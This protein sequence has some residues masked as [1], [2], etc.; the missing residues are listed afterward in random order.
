MRFITKI[1]TAL[2]LFLALAQVKAIGPF[3]VEDIQVEGLQRVEL[4]TFFTALPIR[5]GETI[6]DARVPNIIRSLYKTGNFDFVKLERVDATLKVLVVERPVISSIVLSGNK[7]LKSEQLL[8]NM[9]SSGIEKGEVLNSFILDK[10]EQAITNEYFNN[11]HYHLGIKKQIIDLSRNRVQLKIDIKEGKSARIKGLNII[12]NKLFSDEELLNNMESATGGLFSFLMDDN[13]YS[14]SGLEKDIEAVT[15]FYK[16]RGYLK[17]NVD[18]T[19]VS[20]SDNREEVYISLN[21]TEGNVFNIKNVNL[22]GE[23]VY[24]DDFLK[25]II[26]YNEGDN[27]SQAINTFIEEQIKSLLGLKGFAFAEVRVIPEIIADT[28]E[29]DL[30]VI[31]DPGERYYANDISFV[32]NYIT[33]D[34]VFRREAR[35][36][37]GEPL[38]SSLVERS[39]QRI[40]RL[41][42]AE[43]VNVD[44]RKSEELGEADI[45]YTVKER[46]SSEATFSLGYN[47][48][49]GFQI[50]GGVTNR[51]F[52]GE[53]KTI[54]VN[55]SSNKAV[56]SLNLNYSDPYFFD[57]IIGLSSSLSYKETDFSEFNTVGRSLD[58]LALGAG[59][60]YPI[61]ETSNISFGFNFQD[62]TLN[63]P[64]LNNQQDQRVLDFFELLGANGR[65]DNS[66]DFNVFSLN[67]GY[68]KNTLNRFIFPTSG[69]SHNVGLE[70]ATPVG[71]IEYYK[72][73]YDYKHYFPISN[74]GWIFSI[75]A[76]LGFGDG[77]GDTDRLP[78]F[79]NY[80]AGGSNSLR[81]FEGNTIG[82]KSILR[83]LQTLTVSNPIPGSSSTS[84]VLPPENDLLFINNRFSVG[85]NAKAVASFEL[86]FPTPFVENKNNVR[87]S[88][89]VD[90]GN[91]WDTK[92]DPKR[93]EGLQLINSEL[94]S[95]PDYSDPST[96]RGSYGISLQWYSPIA[97]LQF[98]LS[99]T[100]K[101]DIFDE[102]KTFTFTIGQ[103][104]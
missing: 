6:D 83:Q 33:D 5:V 41:P 7:I 24:T 43:E 39:K 88:A 75:R 103:T 80:Y 23:L 22:V 98:S 4:G 94:S 56:K 18:S 11:G 73:N 65:V 79:V 20:L 74:T 54:G 13:K 52:L 61:S 96:Y 27:F 69:Y 72:L 10:I 50:Q 44:V 28:N 29:V 12:G 92:F 66:V 2:F 3:V 17:F 68:Q 38:S 85:G 81:G 76:N 78:Y 47:D 8:E 9:K 46:S 86:I 99:R 36:K 100:F 57:D 90:V 84:I 19:L 34:N 104:F 60:F 89:F 32:G 26:P 93:F 67:L 97:P 49:F 42:F 70:Y 77:L 1:L 62:N 63:A 64:I 45:V 55:L 71:D 25:R 102:T 30:N 87:T 37:E 58:T 15:S 21:V 16:D 14:S 95:I 40:Q 31:V 59:L 101:S 51:N 82:P 53:G 48:F 35:L 91:V